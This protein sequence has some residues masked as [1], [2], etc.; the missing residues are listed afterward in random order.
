MPSNLYRFCFPYE[1]IPTYWI[2]SQV[3]VIP[4]ILPT[5]VMDL[6]KPNWA[7]SSNLGRYIWIRPEA[8]ANPMIW[9]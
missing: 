1:N 3:V 2:S 4:I 5:Y 8:N 9:Y 6:S 7:M